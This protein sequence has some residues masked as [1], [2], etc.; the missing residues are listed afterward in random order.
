[1]CP[2]PASNK[3]QLP[4]GT[5]GTVFQQI[6]AN[7]IGL[8]L[9][10]LWTRSERKKSAREDDRTEKPIWS[11]KIFLNLFF[12]FRHLNNLEAATPLRNGMTPAWPV[13]VCF[14][15]GQDKNRSKKKELS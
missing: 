1:M 11:A 4:C 6:A 14:L 2:A 15:S 5:Q 12:H 13:P 8:L 9:I 10:I 7:L 3:N